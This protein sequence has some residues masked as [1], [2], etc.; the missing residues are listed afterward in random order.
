[1]TRQRDAAGLVTFDDRILGCAAA[2][3]SGPATCARCCSR[4]I[5]CRPAPGTDAGRPLHQLADALGKRGLIVL[6]SDLLDDPDA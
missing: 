6:I 1:M 2:A 3:A 4:S 5:G